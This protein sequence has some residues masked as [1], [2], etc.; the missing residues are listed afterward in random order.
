MD[1]ALLHAFELSPADKIDE[2]ITL[3]LYHAQW[4][5]AESDD[6]WADNSTDENTFDVSYGSGGYIFLL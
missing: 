2:R 1:N 4:Y 3:A 6:D 5:L